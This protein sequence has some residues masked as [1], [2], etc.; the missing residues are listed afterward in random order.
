MKNVW[1]LFLITFLSSLAYTQTVEFQVDMGVQAYK[2]L[3]N[4]SSDSVKIAGN[5]NGWNNG[6]DVLTDPE[7]DTIYT[8]T[9]TFTSSD[10]L[11]FKFIMGSNSWEHDPNRVYIVLPWDT[12]YADYFNRDSSYFPPTPVQFKFAVDMEYELF[13]GRFNPAT[14]TLSVRGS[15]NGWSDNWVM[16]PIADDPDIYE[17]SNIIYTWP[18]DKIFYKYAY[19]TPNGV[20]WESEPNRDYTVTSDDF[21][22]GSVNLWGSLFNLF[23]CVPQIG[24]QF[25]IKFTVNMNG[26]VSAIN[27]RPFNSVADVRIGRTFNDEWCFM[28]PGPD[29]FPSEG[30]PDEDSI[31]TTKLYDDGT[32]GD[33]VAGDNIWSR[34]IHFPSSSR[35]KIE[36]MYSANWGLPTNNGGNNNESILRKHRIHFP[37]NISS[38]TV[39]D[40]FGRIEEHP[41]TNLIIVDIETETPNLI[42]S[43][44]L[45]QNYPN[46]FN[47]TTTIKYIIPSLGTQRAVSVQLKVYDLL[48]NEVAELVSGYKPAGSYEV[49][50]NIPS[51]LS[52]GIY[53]YQLKASD[54]IATKKM[55][56]LK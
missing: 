23:C 14:D 56:F 12:V 47:P 45:E 17:H 37:P 35:A 28:Y 25:D 6:S 11:Y 42:S 3:F 20:N 26:A 39:V 55:I 8:I 54:F 10:T 7:G 48:G 46:P 9:K 15:F 21:I 36:Y 29:C 40:T 19:K 50:F 18:G 27:Q 43:F 41:L 24:S 22:S 16:T 2:G 33:L 30:W 38:A 32:N 52:S 44:S 5:F 1:V 4:P 34:D 51:S 53:F 13:A 31:K 49:E